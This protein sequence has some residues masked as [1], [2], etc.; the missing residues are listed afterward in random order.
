MDSQGCRT[1]FNKFRT[2]YCEC[3]DPFGSCGLEFD[4]GGSNSCE[5][6]PDDPN[7]TSPIILDVAGDG[8]RLTNVELGV[9]FDL[10]VTGT[11]I[12]TAWTEPDSDDAWLALDRNGNGTIDNGSELFGNFTPQPASSHKNG[13][14]ALAEFDKTANGGNGD[15]LISGQDSVF[16][17]LRLWQ[18]RNHNGVSEQTELLLLPAANVQTLSLDYKE[19]RRRDG[20]GNLFRYR[21]KVNEVDYMYDVFLV[22]E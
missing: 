9:R 16:T 7:C 22:H 15:D 10:R 18:D 14:L 20:H 11:P 21:A 1:C 13:F 3:G 4:G 8:Y 6:E 17:S 5:C 19:S 12:R 2:F